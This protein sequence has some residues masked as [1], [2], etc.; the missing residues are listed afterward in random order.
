LTSRKIQGGGNTGN[1]FTC[2]ALL[3]LFRTKTSLLNRLL[4]HLLQP[5]Q[6]ELDCSMINLLQMK[7]L[8]NLC[9]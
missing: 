8:M 9:L 1:A 7:I 5:F 2:V 4:V 6:N 3:G